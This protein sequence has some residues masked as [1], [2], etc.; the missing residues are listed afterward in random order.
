MGE[1]KNLK[2]KVL[3]IA[4]LYPPGYGGGAAV[5]VHDT[6][7]FLAERGHDIRVLCTESNDTSPYTIRREKV[8]D[9]IVYRLNLPYF[10]DKDPGGWML[11]IAQWKEH[12]VNTIRKLE[13]ILTDWEP[14][15]VQYH[16]PYSLIEECLPS[17]LQRK[18]PIVG[19]THDFWTICLRLGLS[20]SPTDSVC[21]GPSTFKCLE[22]N[23]S[24]WDQTHTKALLKLP[25]RIA[26]LGLFPAYRL[27]NRNNLCQYIDGLI[28]ISKYM[29]DAHQ[30]HVKGEVKH[31]SLGIDLTR[32]P[33]SFENRPRTPLRF[34]F[35]A[36]FVDYKG[37]WDVLDTAK[38][39]KEK[40]YKFEIYI[41]G[42]KQTET[43]LVERNIQD[44]VKLQGLYTPETIWE[45]YQEMDILLVPSRCVESYGRVIQEAAA[46][47]V[48]S[49]AA[50]I[51]GITEQIRD[52][53]DG[54]LFDY[55]D[56]RDLERKMTD[57]I[58]NPDLVR[59][60]ASNLWKVINT[61]DAVTTIEEFYFK[62]LEK[63]V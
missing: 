20:R 14:D 41:W 35:V 45:V 62:I 27:R 40:G 56:R 60:L 1:I 32:L 19:M 57:V 49:I 13:E 5:Y 48:P 59:K 55:R 44:V 28:C 30:G 18:I 22:C 34:G 47:K 58:E 31:L 36:G 51:G 39:L 53:V 50:R 16:T 11:S 6:C 33:K 3:N 61:K 29:A 54:L 9:V 43:P 46:V 26:K 63:K 21:S 25:W 4:E 15:L 2:L 24:Y 38:S 17:L 23:Y 12:C 42:P 10:R 7:Q 52:G 37:I 8:E